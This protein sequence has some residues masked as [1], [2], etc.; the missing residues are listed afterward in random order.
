MASSTITWSPLLFANPIQ[1]HNTREE[2]EDISKQ[3]EEAA[4]EASEVG[5]IEGTQN[6]MNYMNEIKARGFWE[7]TYDKPFSQ[8]M[9]EFFGDIL[10]ALGVFIL[11]NGD[12]FFLMPAIVFMTGTFIIGKNKFTKWIIP[13]WFM[14]FLSR[15]FFRMIL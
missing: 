9:S 3:A 12:I 4:K 11:G 5:F 14:Y 2:L 7:A 10:H 15:A 6:F 8:I 1:K 13:L